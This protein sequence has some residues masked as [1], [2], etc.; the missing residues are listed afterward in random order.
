VPAPRVAAKG[1]VLKIPE[2]LTIDPRSGHV[3]GRQGLPVGGVCKDGYVR[4][5]ARGA[6]GTLYAHRLVWET[7][8]GPIPD[9][10]CID[11]RNAR[12]SDNRISNLRLVTPA[13]N[14]RLTVLRGRQAKGIAMH[15][16]KLNDE[17]VVEIRTTSS[18]VSLSEWA[19]RLGVDQATIRAA[20]TGVTWRHVKCGPRRRSP[21]RRGSKRPRRT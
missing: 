17:L 16:A 8:H 3:Y 10:M 19:K 6:R 1:L 15:C 9:G 21:V 11:H 5:G 2:G 18:A 4:L 7:V 14:S 20:R 12:R 13:E